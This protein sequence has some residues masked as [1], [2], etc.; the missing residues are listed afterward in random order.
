MLDLIVR[1]IINA[2]AL[3]VASMVVPNLNLAIGN[4]VQDWVKVG[5]VALLLGL[6]NSYLRP[7][8][9]ALA[10]P[11]TLL[12]LGLV[13]IA[14]NAAMLLILS[15][16]SDVLNLPF[17]VNQFPDKGLDGNTILAAVLGAIIVGLVAAVI[18]FVF[19]GKR[20]LRM[21]L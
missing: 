4:D 21:R 11:I 14:I 15:F 7:I 20:V 6:I 13:G 5:A 18:G 9:S 2:A 12:T 1:V 16:V 10:M 19:S 3:I 8:V 17:N